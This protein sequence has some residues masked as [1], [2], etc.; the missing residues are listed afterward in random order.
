MNR[1]PSKKGALPKWVV[2]LLVIG[3]AFVGFLG[4]RVVQFVKYVREHPRQAAPGE[5][6]FREA[7]RQII[8]NKGTAAFG[9]N[10]EAIA[11]AQEY[12]RKLKALRE[13]FFTKGKD[14]AFSLSKG[15]LLT[16][17]QWN[18]DSCV[19]LVHVPELRRFESDAKK[20][21]TDL[22]WMSAH[23]VLQAKGGPPPKTV[24]VGVKGA[25]LYEAILIG[26][27][28]SNPAPDGEGV[29]QRG[30]GITEEKLF[31]PFFAPKESPALSGTKS[32]VPR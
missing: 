32:S 11:L 20:S 24:A 31:Y 15:E 29:K 10:R 17:C 4:F 30:S 16:F 3:V 27:L 13:V 19:F 21:L 12:S 28:L 6:E 8:A 26:D 5:A 23:V 7:N 22:A 14:D 18:G 1:E 25:L 9:N 2:I